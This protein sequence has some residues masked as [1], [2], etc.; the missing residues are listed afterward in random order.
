MSNLAFVDL[1]RALRRFL[2]EVLLRTFLK[3]ML[4]RRVLRRSLV[5]LSVGTEGLLEAGRVS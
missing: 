1:R 3:E 2:K 4:L 5:G